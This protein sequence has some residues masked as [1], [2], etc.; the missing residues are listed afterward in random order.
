METLGGGGLLIFKSRLTWQLKH[1]SL[2]R[3]TILHGLNEQTIYMTRGYLPGD[4]SRLR[5]ICREGANVSK[6]GIALK[7]SRGPN[8]DE[9]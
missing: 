1:C 5:H 9:D 2:H 4:D 6:D 7:A 8:F 3:R